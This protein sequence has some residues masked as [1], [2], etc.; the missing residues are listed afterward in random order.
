MI[1]LADSQ[2]DMPIG[3]VFVDAKGEPG[4]IGRDLVDP[5][6]YMSPHRTGIPAEVGNRRIA[7][8]EAAI[9]VMTD[10]RHITRHTE[11]A[12]GKE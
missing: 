9:R 8:C 5:S 3:V 11:T 4:W 2:P 12:T 1:H 10:D 7:P 6:A